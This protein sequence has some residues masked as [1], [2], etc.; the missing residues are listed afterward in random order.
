MISVLMPVYN[1]EKYL[2]DSIKSILKPSYK[3]FE[4]LIYDDFSKD[5]SRNIIKNFAQ[6]DPRIKFFFSE[7]NI[8][9]SRLLNKMTK[10]A[11]FNFYARMDSDDISMEKRFEKQLNFLLNNSKASVVG[12][13]IEIIDEN[14]AMIRRSKY[15]TE[16]RE[17]K[18]ELKNYCT[19]AHPATM[20]NSSYLKHVGGYR[21][22]IEPVEDYDLWTRLSLISTMH[23]L[24]EYLLKYR[25]HLKSI[26]FTK[27]NDQFI[28]T[29]IVK[30]NYHNLL[31]GKNDIILNYNFGVVSKTK[32]AQDFP[33]LTNM[34]H[35]NSYHDLSIT[36]RKKKYLVFIYKF[37]ILFF[38]KPIYLIRKSICFLK[39][40]F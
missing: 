1:S 39:R 35:D 6:Q 2:E 9:Y 36:F 14:G 20:I 7:K 8:G 13:Y 29:E 21:C 5:N 31:N 22:N 18:N 17:I 32:L 11:K 23:N 33:F 25:Q 37:I 3:N 40:N 10:D 26:S 38:S 16:F 28:K 27:T 4:F 19:F 24:P 12:S 15:P 34:I 30:K